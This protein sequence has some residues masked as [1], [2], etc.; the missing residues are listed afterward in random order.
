M[1]QLVL[2][3]LINLIPALSDVGQQSSE[4]AARTFTISGRVLNSHGQPA[5]AG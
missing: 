4:L 5:P 2:L 1:A 3:C